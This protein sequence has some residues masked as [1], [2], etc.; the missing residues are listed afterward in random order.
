LQRLRFRRIVRSIARRCVAPLAVSASLALCLVLTPHGALGAQQAAGPM[1][2]H[3][4]VAEHVARGDRESV[5]RR[6]AAAYEQY[7]AA[8]ALGPES[9]DALWRA[10][11]EAVD[12]GE[13][14]T[15]SARRT[16]LN[17]QA[18]SYAR[19]AVAVNPVGADGHFQLARALG[20]TALSV[21]ARER[22]KYATEIRAE[23]VRALELQPQHAGA[24]HIMGVWNAEVMRL[25]GITRALA[26][27][28]L[29]AGVFGSASWANAT[30]Y[31]EQSVSADPTR[32]IHHLDLA[33]VYRDTNRRADARAAYQAA[34]RSPVIDSNDDV[35]RRAAESE[36]R[37]L[38]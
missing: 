38:K 29:G 11:R 14:E 22:V 31:L 24:L 8:I 6:P 12:L 20:R 16:R 1:A 27:N 37:A 7:E 26:R 32:L 4:S 2:M 10:S 25:N 15:N 5:A 33:R 13:T 36:L 30:R 19:R 28:F 23:A 34:L 3:G 18:V 9:Y 17:E 21:S 35:Y